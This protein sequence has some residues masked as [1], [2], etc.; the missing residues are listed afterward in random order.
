MQDH[1]ASVSSEAEE[2][3]VL[4]RQLA[5]LQ[6]TRLNDFDVVKRIGDGAYS[7]VFKVRR[8]ADGC[9]YALKKVNLPKFKE[10][11]KINAIN[12]VRILASIRHPNVIQYKEAFVDDEENN[13]Q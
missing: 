3:L 10:K 6:K 2:P 11:E 12:E 13:L 7:Q 1:L 4:A 8:K 5:P 9:V